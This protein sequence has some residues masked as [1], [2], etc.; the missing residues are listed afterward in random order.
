MHDL[1]D[2]TVH[3]DDWL[4]HFSAQDLMPYYRNFSSL[5]DGLHMEGNCKHAGTGYPD[6]EAYPCF[7]EVVAYGL[8]TKGFAIEAPTRP[9]HIDVD[10]RTEPN[11]RNNETAVPLHATVTARELTLGK[12]YALYRYTGFNSFPQSDLEHGYERKVPFVAAADTW[13]HRDPVPFLSSNATYY[14]VAAAA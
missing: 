6:R 9:V 8:A 12:S 10:R 7:Y 14:V 5:E 2:P 4:L 11:V 13:T 3:D 1:S